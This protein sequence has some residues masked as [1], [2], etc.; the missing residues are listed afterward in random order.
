[1]S[2]H[3][4]LL[5]LWLLLQGAYFAHVIFCYLVMLT[6]VGAFVSRVVPSFKWTHVWFGRW[7]C[8]PASAEPGQEPA[9]CT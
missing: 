7:V 5:L 8:A 6:G 9:G 4:E 1:M 3:S 2:V